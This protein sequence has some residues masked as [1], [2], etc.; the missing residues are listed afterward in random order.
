MTDIFD[1]IMDVK[2]ASE[3]WGL[4][5]VH[6]KRLCRDGEVKARKFGKIWIIDAAQENPKK[7]KKL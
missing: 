3:K 6:V 7:Y 4:S 1:H 5:E 2:K